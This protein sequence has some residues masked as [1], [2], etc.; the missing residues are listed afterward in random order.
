M[1]KELLQKVVAGQDFSE[2]EAMQAMEQ[3]MDGRATQAQIA[4]LLTALKLKG[5]TIAEITG[6]AR[7]MRSKATPVST[8][9]P[10]LVD[11]CGTGGDGANTFN[12]STVAALVLAGSGVK[13]AKHGNRSVSSRCGSADVLEALGV[14]LDLEPDEVSACLDEVGIAFLYAPSLHGAMKYAAAPRRELGFRTVFNILGPLTNPAGA[15]AQVLG[16]YSPTLVH[17]LTEVLLRLGAERAFVIHG[18]GGL[19]EMS[20]FGPALVGEVNNGIIK[21]Y[22]IDPLAYGF[23]EAGIEKLS[24]GSP[25]ENAAIVRSILEGETGPRRDAVL[26]NA[27]LGLMAA[28]LACEFAEG[29]Q[30]AAR[31][32]DHGLARAKLQDMI[33][34]TVGCRKAR[35]A[36]L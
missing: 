29:V 30:L 27:G 4:G 8:R 18:A 23:T 26:M 6:F 22:S 16:V 12:I 31:S 17:V 9:H 28:G 13:V 1:L 14:N 32:I 3:V 36:G 5:E 24:G 25:E 2:S 20:P 33:D 21:E 34:F 19:D 11:T 15:K 35:V 7:V 10:L